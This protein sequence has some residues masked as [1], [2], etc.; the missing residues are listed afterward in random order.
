MINA[1]HYTTTQNILLEVAGVLTIIPIAPFINRYIP[2][3]MIGE[4]NLDLFVSIVAAFILIRLLLKLFKPLIIPV[5]IIMLGLFVFNF[6]SKGYSFRDVMQDYRSVVLNKWGTKDSKQQD[7]LNINPSFFMSY[8]DKT[9][10]GIRSKVNYRDSVVRNYS[11]KYSLESF[12]EYFNKYG[13]LV[14]HLSLF[15]H[16]NKNFKYVS[17]SRRDEY[18][19][20]RRK[21]FRTAWAAIATIIVS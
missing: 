8:Y 2:P 9:V 20:A 1:K 15:K 11:V 3:L 17:D 5:L 14:R 19:A 12:D 4:W 7:F 18:F 16:I 21:P 13:P 10:R 6:F